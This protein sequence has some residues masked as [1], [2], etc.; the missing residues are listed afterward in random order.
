MH[1]TFTQVLVIEVSSSCRLP[2]Q[3][4]VSSSKSTVS[5]YIAMGQDQSL[6]DSSRRWFELHRDG[7]LYSFSR[8]TVSNTQR[9]TSLVLDL[10]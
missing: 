1:D 7:V 4:A 6:I 2:I 3:V 9:F 8:L 5:G 10:E